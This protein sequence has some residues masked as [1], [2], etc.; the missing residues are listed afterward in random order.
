M[1]FLQTI[2]FILVFI[3]PWTLAF[4]SE[5]NEILSDVIPGGISSDD[6]PVNDEIRGIVTQVHSEIKGHLLGL[7]GGRNIRGEILPISYRTQLVNGV[8]YFIKVQARTPRKI[9]Y[10]HL[11][12]YKSFNGTP[13][14]MKVEG[15]KHESDTINFF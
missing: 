4:H 2:P 7:P 9:I 10:Y 12:I 11:R 5:E 3:V 8:N 6:K 1:K 15:P 13:R 14:L